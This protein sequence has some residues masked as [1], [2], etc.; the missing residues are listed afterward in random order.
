MVAL[1]EVAYIYL[2]KLAE[3]TL[4]LTPLRTVKASDEFPTW[5]KKHEFAFES[6]KQ[7][8]VSRE[9]LT[10]IDHST[11]DKNTIFVTT[12]ASD[13]GTGAVNHSRRCFGA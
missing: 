13:W 8:V 1:C 7:L 4:V 11:L 9:C 6:I 2:P 12:D 5:T 3:H 10:V